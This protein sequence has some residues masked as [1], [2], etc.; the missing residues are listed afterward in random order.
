[1]RRMIPAHRGHIVN[2]G[3]LASLSPVP[4]LSLYVAS[5]FAVRGFT[6]SAAMELREHGVSV[7]LI[8]PDAVETPMLDKQVAYKEAAMTFSGQRPLTVHDIERLIVDTVL[9]YK[10]LEAA[11]P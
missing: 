6:L 3:S 5:K 10:P 2:I 9:P 8:M 4:G 11:I 7:T 1:A